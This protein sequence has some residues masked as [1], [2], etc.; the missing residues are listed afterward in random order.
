MKNMKL[1][2][3]TWKTKDE[4]KGVPLFDSGEVYI[5]LKLIGLVTIGTYLFSSLVKSFSV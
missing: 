3:W 1:N 4:C 2:F 5:V